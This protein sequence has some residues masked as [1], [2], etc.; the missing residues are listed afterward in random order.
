VKDSTVNRVKLTGIY[1]IK[2]RPLG[3]LSNID[4]VGTNIILILDPVI[5]GNDIEWTRRV[6]VLDNTYFK[7]Y[8]TGLNPFLF[9]RK[10]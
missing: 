9:K 6:L 2:Q 4:T 3:Y 5:N 1:R 10:D 8:L 7:I